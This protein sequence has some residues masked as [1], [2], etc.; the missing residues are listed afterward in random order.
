MRILH[1]YELGPLGDDRV[2]G[3]LEI[4]ILEL[5]RAL[6][7]RGHQVSVLAGAGPDGITRRRRIDG[8]E[9]IPVDFLGLMRRTWSAAS[10]TTARQ[11]FFPLAARCLRGYDVYH[12]HVY[13][14]GFL[15]WLMA[16]RNRAVSVNTIHGSYY[17]VWARITP[18]GKALVFK[19]LERL[20]VPTLGRIVDLQIHT[21]PEFAAQVMEWG[22]PRERIAYIPNGVDHEVFRAD[23]PEWEVRGRIFTARRLVRKNGLEYLIRALGHLN[24]GGRGYHLYIAGEGPER[25]RLRSLSRSLGL[26]GCVTFLGPVSH[27]DVAAH[28]ARSEL[29]V[30]PSLVEATSLFALEAL[31]MGKIVV[32]SDTEGLRSV[33]NGSNGVLV[34]PCDPRAIAEAIQDATSD[35]SRGRRIRMEAVKTA[36]KYSWGR[37]AE[38]TEREYERLMNERR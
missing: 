34:E 4:A 27:R 22:V 30:I 26:D 2:Y 31:A 11:V 13:V 20:L 19:A 32:A 24:G 25:R 18:R 9:V 35:P 33:I 14:S 8:V 15:A 17:N 28:L 16:R 38:L 37:I 3:G 36:R 21:S 5:C 7:E 6:V 12:G 29:A 1:I 23:P 10:L